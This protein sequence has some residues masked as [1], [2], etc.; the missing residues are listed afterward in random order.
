M[1]QTENRLPGFKVIPDSMR[2]QVTGDELRK[3]LSRYDR[4][5]FMD[6]LA[7]W[8]ECAPEPEDVMTFARKKPDLYVNAVT[9]L[10]RLAGFTEKREV[11]VNHTLRLGALSDSQLEDRAKRLAL[12]MGIGP[13]LIE[14]TVVAEPQKEGGTEAFSFNAEDYYN[15]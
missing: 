11:E 5:P 2:P 12:A 1:A 9:S 7:A 3:A 13:L 4:Q 6:V 10:A 14:G 15:K 8:L